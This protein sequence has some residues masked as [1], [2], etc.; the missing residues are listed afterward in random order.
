M[1]QGWQS[2]VKKNFRETGKCCE[3][4]VLFKVQGG[5]SRKSVFDQMRRIEVPV[6]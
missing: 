3:R 1:M 2:Q 6:P 5:A 4:P